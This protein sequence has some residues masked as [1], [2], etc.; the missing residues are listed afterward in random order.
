MMNFHENKF[1]QQA[2]VALMDIHDAV[3]EVEVDDPTEESIERLIKAAEEVTSTIADALT[4][5]DKG[6]TKTLI[7]NAVGLIAVTRT[8]LAVAWGRG[9]VDDTK[10]KSLDDAYAALSQS[11]QQSK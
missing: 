3:D 9:V 11:L 2:Y 4:R 5:L 1:W 10:F 6:V 7:H 8:Q